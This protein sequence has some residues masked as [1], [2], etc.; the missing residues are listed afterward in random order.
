[1]IGNLKMKILNA[2]L[3]VNNLPTFKKLL[4][5]TK[6]QILHIKLV[7]SINQ[8]CKQKK[9]VIS[10]R[11]HTLS[12]KIK[13]TKNYISSSIQALSIQFVFSCSAIKS[14]IIE[15]VP[16]SLIAPDLFKITRSICNNVLNDS[17]IN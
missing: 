17:N 8:K 13:K 4:F 7:I 1:M 12:K 6:K 9:S 11:N 10:K 15:F 14:L 5:L 16:S 3:N 2:N